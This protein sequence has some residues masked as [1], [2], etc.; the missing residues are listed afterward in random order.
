M[1]DEQIDALLKE[2]THRLEL[3]EAGHR[4]PY[5]RPPPPGDKHWPAWRYPPNGGEGRIFQRLDDVPE[6]WRDA[7]QPDKAK[8][9][10]AA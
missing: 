6:D 5:E 7:P 2:H 3:L 1:T 4:K 8:K 10:K 9:T